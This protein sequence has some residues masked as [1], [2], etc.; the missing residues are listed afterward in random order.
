MSMRKFQI[1]EIVIL[2]ALV[3]LFVYHSVSLDF[4]QDDAYISYRYVE[5][6]VEGHGLVFNYGERVEGYTNFLWIMLLSLA[7]LAGLPIIHVSKYVGVACGAGTLVIA[8]LIA[9]EFSDHKRWYLSL[10]PPAFLAVNG[11]LAYWVIGGLETGL[12][13]FLFSLAVLAEFR[14]PSLTPF[15]LVLATLTRPEGGLLFGIVLLYRWLVVRRPLGSLA[16]YTGIYIGLLVPYAVFKLVYFGDLLPNP[17]YAKTGMSLEYLSS[18]FEYFWK[19]AY[20]YGLFGLFLLTPLPFVKRL[21]GRVWLLWLALLIYTGYVIMVGGDVLKAHRFFLPI[22]PIFF[23]IIAYVC[24]ELLIGRKAHSWVPVLTAAACIGYVAWSFIVPR[25]YVRSTRYL[26][27]NFVNKMDFVAQEL[28]KVDPSDFSIA[29]TTIGKV[30]YTLK[31]HKVIDMLGLTDRYIAKNPEKIEGMSTTWKERNFNSAYL[32]ELKPDYILFSTGHKPSAPAERALVLNSHFRRNYS[33][34]GFYMDGRVKVVW[35]RRG[36]FSEPN[37]QLEGTEFADLLYDGLNFYTQNR[38]EESLEK[39]RK[40]EELCNG[41]F[42]LLEFFIGQE[43]RFV[44]QN[45]EA[46][47]HFMRALQLDRHQ[48]ETMVLLYDQYKATG[49][50]ENQQVMAQALRETAPWILEQLDSRH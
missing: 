25:E 24:Y 48:M 7:S 36:D 45:S 32:L 35:K 39:F 31:G 50:R 18:G 46:M 29:A 15:T 11:A 14:R 26:E 10:I 9:R 1:K 22:L 47:E 21:P 2:A 19:F 30:S 3:A 27:Y 4:T 44:G 5:N 8:F 38:H 20:H 49:D 13:V 34:I 23:A 6:F 28:A 42:P 40:A 37:T 41:D 33:T 43:Y 17:F 12:F 16:A